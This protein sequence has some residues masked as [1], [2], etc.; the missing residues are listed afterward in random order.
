[1]EW[2]IFYSEASM[3]HYLYNGTDV[4]DF[5]PGERI[6]WDDKVEVLDEV[7]RNPRKKL[8]LHNKARHIIVARG[9][10]LTNE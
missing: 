10:I 8:F 9:K 5:T 4:I 3:H 1:M 2:M 7:L 6:L